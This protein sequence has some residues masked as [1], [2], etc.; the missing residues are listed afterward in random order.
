MIFHI[1]RPLKI[2]SGFNAFTLLE[3]LIVTVIIAIVVGISTPLFRRTLATIQLAN[4]TQ[5]IA[6]LMRFLRVKAISEKSVYQLKFDFIEGKYYAVKITVGNPVIYDNKKDIPQGINI[7]STVNPI[8]FYSDG[9]IEGVKIYLFK[10]KE[11]FYKDIDKAIGKDFDIGQIQNVART[12]YI[13]VIDVQSSI[14]KV[15]VTEPK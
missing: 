15:N 2:K 5:D 10:G 6:Q 14:G 12:E 7:V 4:T 1:K 11:E 9:S 8:R 13:Y 3:I